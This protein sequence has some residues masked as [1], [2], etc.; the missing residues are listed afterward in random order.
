MQG[1]FEQIG[2]GATTSSMVK[3]MPYWM[4]GRLVS[5]G[6]TPGSRLSSL[7]AMGSA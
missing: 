7:E 4:K 2:P 6:P 1:L 3:A 5:G